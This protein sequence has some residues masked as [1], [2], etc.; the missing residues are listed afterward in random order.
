[1]S[2]ASARLLR[3][4]VATAASGAMVLTSTAAAE[5]SPGNGH[6]PVLRTTVT[7]AQFSLPATVP[8]GLVTFAMTGGDEDTHA[9]QGF[10]VN[11]GSTL[12]E[13]KED[14]NQT[15]L[16][17]TFAGRAEGAEELNEHA[18]LIG[19]VVT[20]PGREIS[21]TVPLEE[22]TYYFFDLNDLGNPD[23][24][25]GA[26]YREMRAVGRFHPAGPPPFDTAVLA[27]EHDE[28]WMFHG[29]EQMKA[30]GSFLFVN[31]TPEIHEVVFRQT[32]PPAEL[33]GDADAYITNFYNAV[34]AGTPRPPSPWL[35]S[36]HGLQ[37]LSPG[38]WAVT[39]ID[40]APGDYSMICY[41]PSDELGFPHAYIGMHQQVELTG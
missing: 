34:L 32:R 38:R 1:M 6:I 4:A 2:H 14:F 26:V 12:D 24:P 3:M 39:H 25:Q 8:S 29:P 7:R 11:P 16:S 9:V 33:G 41:V 22:G 18:T 28:M 30:N 27:S 15:L 21:V 13:V 35:D 20:A 17:D 5:A 23:V 37:S 40:L 19:G 10:R 36:Q 31:T